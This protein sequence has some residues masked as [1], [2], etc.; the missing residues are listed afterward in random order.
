MIYLHYKNLY[1]YTP[2]HGI[3]ICSLLRNNEGNSDNKNHH[4]WKLILLIMLIIFLLQ[5]NVIFLHVESL[6]EQLAFLRFE[7]KAVYSISFLKYQTFK[8]IV[9]LFFSNFV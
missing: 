7:T 3:Q 9:T 5:D 1:V 8:A 4:V 2:F 6:K